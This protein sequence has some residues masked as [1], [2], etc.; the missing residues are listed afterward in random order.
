MRARAPRSTAVHHGAAAL[1]LLGCSSSGGPGT[2][3]SGPGGSPTEAKYLG[4]TAP[5]DGFQV[6]SVGTVIH[7]GEDVEYCELQELPGTADQTYYVK[8][9]EFA[10]GASSHHLIIDSVQPGGVSEARV[11]AMKLGEPTPC[12]SSQGIAGAGLDFMGGTQ[13]PY[14]KVSFPEGV[15]RV[16]HGGQRVVFDYHY[17]NTGTTDVQA[18]SAANFHLTDAAHTSHI[19]QIFL[20]NNVTI[21]TPPGKTASFTGECRMKQDVKVGGLTRHTHRWGTDYA[22][23][24]AG[25]AHD[26]EQ[27]FATSDF[28]HGTDHR[29]PEAITVKSGEGFRFQCNY[30][31]TETHPLRFGP[32]ATDEMCILLGLWWTA[33]DGD[34]PAS[35][36]C[37]MTQT[38]T[39]GI[40]RPVTTGSS[41]AKPTTEEVTACLASAAKSSSTSAACS[42]CTCDACAGLIN[43]CSSDPD[44]SAILSCIVA[45]G[46]RDQGTCINACG[47]AINDHSAGTGMFITTTQC[48]QQSCSFCTGG[49]DAGVPA[50]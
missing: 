42:Q 38:G 36:D 41:F 49:A 3:G 33:A 45:S 8:E 35:Q 31:N 9:I 12:L 23:W 27:I 2:G 6:R 25:G 20:L 15:G 5:T 47:T 7:P 11:K 46:C 1:I 40:A 24:Y 17:L 16:Y 4:L 21:N 18:K 44:C 39:D 50:P 30:N 14:E 48:L 37:T 13:T 28:E 10:N 26:S 34:K 22:V 32:N 43:G 19:A 29:F